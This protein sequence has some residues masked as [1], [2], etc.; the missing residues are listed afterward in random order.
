[1]PKFY[2]K[3]VYVVILCYNVMICHHM[4][5]ISE[6]LIY[7]WLIK[8]SIW[9]V[10]SMHTWTCTSRNIHVGQISY[11]LCQLLVCSGK[12]QLSNYGNSQCLDIDLA[13]LY[14]ISC[15]DYF[16]SWHNNI[17]YIVTALNSTH[18]HVGGDMLKYSHQAISGRMMIVQKDQEDSL[19]FCKLARPANPHQ[20]R[21]HPSVLSSA[22]VTCSKQTRDNP[23]M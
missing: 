8:L 7:H 23:E 11:I 12:S 18:V 13:E 21:R 20:Q 14:I 1:M 15:R 5:F 10:I 19:I 4:K 3:Y 17:R 16:M 22:P 9:Q 6:I 2:Q